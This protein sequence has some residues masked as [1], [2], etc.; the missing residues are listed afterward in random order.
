MDALQAFVCAIQIDNKHAIAWLNLGIL[1]ETS[2]YI[3]DALICY[4]KS[5]LEKD[6]NWN[7]ELIIRI[8]KL[9]TCLSHIPENSLDKQLVLIIIIKR[10]YLII[11]SKTCNQLPKVKD[12]FALPIPVELTAKQQSIPISSFP[13]S[14]TVVHHNHC[15]LS[16]QPPSS[17]FSSTPSSSNNCKCSIFF[18]SF[19]DKTIVYIYSNNKNSSSINIKY[20]SN[21]TSY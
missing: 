9:Q 10:T 21:K 11:F 8:N 20:A 6:D 16:T 12:A 14:L 18:Y 19:I 5:I 7:P 2:G 4:R 13:S 17:S 15:P 3:Q 1:Y